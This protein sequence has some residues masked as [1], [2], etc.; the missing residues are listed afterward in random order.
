MPERGRAGYY[1]FALRATSGKRCSRASM[2]DAGRAD[3]DLA[4]PARRFRAGEAD[5]PTYASALE[6]LAVKGEWDVVQVAGLFLTELRG[7]LLDEKAA[8]AFRT[9][10]REVLAPRMAKVGL[11]PKPREAA[12]ATLL[13][14]SLAELLIKEARDPATVSAL[15]RRD[16]LICARRRQ[17][18]AYHL[19]YAPQH[20]GQPS[21]RAAR[22]PC[23]TSSPRSKAQVISNFARMLPSH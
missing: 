12:A 22:K 4:Q 3:L 8:A 20:C 17:T 9:K 18:A 14:A 23:A 5:G 7:D 10:L 16:S 6:H 13:R 1:R 19:S 2:S 11:S 21:T 15:A